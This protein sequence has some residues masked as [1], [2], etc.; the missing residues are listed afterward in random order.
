[1]KMVKSSDL[2]KLILVIQLV[3]L[4]CAVPLGEEANYEGGV[5]VKERMKN[6]QLD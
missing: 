3:E 6:Q 2:L 1:M 4:C 5:S